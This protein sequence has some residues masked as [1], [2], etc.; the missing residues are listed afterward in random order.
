[1]SGT[2]LIGMN[3]VMHKLKRHLGINPNEE[4]EVVVDYEL[5]RTIPVNSKKEKRQ[6]RFIRLVLNRLGSAFHGGE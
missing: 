3:K 4:N 6:I 5:E 2:E 1:M